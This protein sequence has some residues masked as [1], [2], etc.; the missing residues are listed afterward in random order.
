MATT[1]RWVQFVVP[2]MVEVDCDDDEVTRVVVLA[3]EVR[4]D[5]DDLGH[6]CIYVEGFARR[7]SDEQPQ[8][9][10]LFGCPAGVGAR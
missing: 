10:R 1:R 2:V 3:E 9:Q 7:H 8:T 4:P 6:F 5:R